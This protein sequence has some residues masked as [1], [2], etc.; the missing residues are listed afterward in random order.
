[1]KSKLWW[2]PQD[3]GDARNVEFLPGKTQAM[4][5][6]SLGE[7][8]VPG[9]GLPKDLELTSCFHMLQRPDVNYRI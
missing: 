3:V 8:K 4:R 5:G 1:V 7:R 9:V 6:V 2:I